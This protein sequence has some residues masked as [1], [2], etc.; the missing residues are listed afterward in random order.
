VKTIALIDDDKSIR[1]LFTAYLCKVGYD[2]VAYDNALDFTEDLKKRPQPFDLAI[3]DINMPKV[4]GLELLPWLNRY[5]PNMCT[6]ALTAHDDKQIESIAYQGGA[7]L[8]LKKP[9]KLDYLHRVIRLLSQEG[10]S[11]E[12][13]HVTLIDCLQTLACDSEARVLK[14]QEDGRSHLLVA[15]QYNQVQGLQYVGEND[16]RQGVDALEKLICIGDATFSELQAQEH[17]ALIAQDLRIPLPQVALH[18]A[19]YQDESATRPI[20]AQ[21]LGIDG[22]AA[23]KQLLSQILNNMG[24]S[25]S[26]EPEACHAHIV[27]Q[28]SPDTPQRINSYPKPTLVAQ[29]EMALIGPSLSPEGLASVQTQTLH[30][31]G[32]WAAYIKTHFIRGL[33]GTLNKISVFQLIQLISQASTTGCIRIKDL[34]KQ[35]ESILYFVQG[36]LVEA[37]LSKDLGE[38]ALLESMRIRMGCFQQ[39]PFQTPPSRQLENYS[40]TRLLMNYSRPFELED[41]CVQ[42]IDG[43]ISA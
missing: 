15:L 7:C 29:Q 12:I 25:V 2:C 10:L 41:N 30:S 17:T 16:P 5:H 28:S 31:V 19:Q 22:P 9:L 26:E 42:K 34:I 35:R 39:I 6:I 20:K 11:G 4:S 21:T 36:K 18:I 40:V 33:S 38:V 13:F 23:Q 32:E 24:F 43:L 3:T 8:F 27:M 37:C 1:E 14:I